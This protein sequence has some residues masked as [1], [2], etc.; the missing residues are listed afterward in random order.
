LRGGVDGGFKRDREDAEMPSPI[1]YL[2]LPS[3]NL[4]ADKQFY[5]SLFGWTFE[6]F[7]PK[8]AAI[9]S[10]G[11]E[12]GLNAG[13]GG[14][15]NA[16]LPVINTDDIEAMEQRVTQAGGT[17][18]VPTFAFPGGRRFHFTDLSGNELAV[19]QAD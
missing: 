14:R 10:A 18:T 6:N 17:I 19:M 3:N 12:G 11:L 5:A 16:P 7:G 8:Y 2:E 9:H 15:S 1:V 13:K 4:A